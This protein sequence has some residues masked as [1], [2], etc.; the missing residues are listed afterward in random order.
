MRKIDAKHHVE[1]TPEGIQAHFEPGRLRIVNTSTGLPIPD[2]EPLF[3][4]RA[5]DNLAT[6]ALSYYA[7][8]CEDD[9]CTY[10]QVEGVRDAL[11]KFLAFKRQHPDKMKQPGSTMVKPG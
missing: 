7:R 10:S 1:Q 5:R 11:S 6:T 9:G 2:D 8:R 3:L 4:F